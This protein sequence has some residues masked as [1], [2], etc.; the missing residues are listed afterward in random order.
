MARVVALLL[1][2]VGTSLGLLLV[3]V[4]LAGAIGGDKTPEA[5][6]TS[7]SAAPG[8]VLLLELG[9]AAALLGWLAGRG[10]A[11]RPV[12]LPPWWASALAFAVAVGAGWGAL[13]LGQW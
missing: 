8:G 6:L 11:A 4:G 1:G 3:G 12:A 9:L 13:Q 7:A 5:F 2:I 10:V